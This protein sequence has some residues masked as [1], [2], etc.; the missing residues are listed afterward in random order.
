MGCS[1]LENINCP[2]NGSTN[3][4]PN[5]PVC[6]EGYTQDGTRC[7]KTK[8]VSAT[9]G[10]QSDYTVQRILPRNTFGTRGTVIHADGFDKDMTYNVDTTY[11]FPEDNLFWINTP[12]SSILGAFNLTYVP[13][14]CAPNKCYNVGVYPDGSTG[15][16]QRNCLHYGVDN[17]GPV[18]R[19]GVWNDNIPTDKWVGFSYCFETTSEDIPKKLFVGLASNAYM[20]IVVDDVV[21]LNIDSKLKLV[22]LTERLIE[23]HDLFFEY[24][25]YNQFGNTDYSANTIYSISGCHQVYNIFPVTINST[26]VHKIDILVQKPITPIGSNVYPSGT[27]IPYQG[28]IACEIYDCTLNEL[29]SVDSLSDLAGKVVFRSTD[30][31]GQSFNYKTYTCPPG[32]T[33]NVESCDTVPTCTY[34]EYVPANLPAGSEGKSPVCSDPETCQEFYSTDWVIYD[35]DD[36]G[37]Q[38]VGFSPEGLSPMIY[39]DYWTRD[40][41]SITNVLQEIND[42]LCYIYSKDFIRYFILGM[43]HED[44]CDVQCSCGSCEPPRY[45]PTFRNSTNTSVNLDIFNKVMNQPTQ[46]APLVINLYSNNIVFPANSEVVAVKTDIN[47]SA[48]YA[49]FGVTNQQP[50]TTVTIKYRIED[51][52]GNILSAVGFVTLAY[53]QSASTVTFSPFTYTLGYGNDYYM[54]YEVINVE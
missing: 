17:A 41:R 52:Y 53:G 6:P 19:L 43:D 45:R 37:C 28:L 13:T 21:V 42:K 27:S 18:N 2:D 4:L 51:Y 34:T 30:F 54:V 9:I 50:G 33:K 36:I 8:E 44:I 1:C 26:G 20:R 39:D 16:S 47:T 14:G 48:V 22:N 49:Y 46:S 12:V 32:F 3:E 29:K 7:V 15:C 23:D 24:G 10:G 40:E 11:R 31:L 38:D 5:G 25:F 35:G